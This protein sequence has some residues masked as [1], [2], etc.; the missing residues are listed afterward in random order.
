MLP[1]L[2]HAEECHLQL[3][4]DVSDL[5]GSFLSTCK[6]RINRWLI[7]ISK[8]KKEDFLFNY[9]IHLPPLKIH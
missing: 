5:S 4:R 1:Y 3:S 6:S 2:V 9:L 8:N 7:K